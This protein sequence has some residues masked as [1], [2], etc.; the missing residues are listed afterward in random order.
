MLFGAKK[1]IYRNWINIPGW[2]TKRKIVVIESDDWGAIRMPSLEIR[3][4]LKQQGVH[5]SSYGYDDVDTLASGEDLES[6]FAVLCRYKDKNG[7]HPV[8]T[9]NTIMTNP[10]F[11]KI[12]QSG[13]QNYYYELFI[14]TLGR[15]Y[16]N[17]NIFAVW[18]EGIRAGIFQPQFHGREHVNVQMWLEQLRA[19]NKSV[20][21]AFDCGVYSLLIQEDSRRK[22]LHA[23]NIAR[24]E[25]KGFVINSI[26]EGLR[27]FEQ[28]FGFKSFSAIPPSFTWDEFVEQ[29]YCENGVKYIQGSSVQ[30]TSKLTR[31]KVLRHHTG[32]LNKQ[33]Q[34]YMV[35]NVS[36]EPS[37]SKGM[38]VVSECMK[39]I[40]NAFFWHKPAIISAHRLNFIGGLNK[41]NRLDNLAMLDTLLNKIFLDYPDVEFM[42]TDQLGKLIEKK[43]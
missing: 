41:R 19:G 31:N 12:E 16:P 26:S 20:M 35:R 43:G 33:N 11:R 39:E 28:T 24:E 7:N 32:Q 3:D 2:K 4:K 13:F 34:I 42:S 21:K 27:L 9:A 1:Y 36:F 15:Y 6:L 8:I 29:V 18:Q 14:D 38:D 40:R 5:F 23:Y 37:Q 22:F 10:D 30:C 25:E 17:E